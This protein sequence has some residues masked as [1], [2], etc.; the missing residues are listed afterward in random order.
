MI[1]IFLCVFFQSDCLYDYIRIED[2]SD[3]P[4]ASRF[5]RLLC[6][7][8]Y[9]P[10]SYAISGHKANLSF[11]SDYDTS[12]HGFHLKWKAIN[13]SQ[14]KNQWLNEPSGTLQSMNYPISY[15]NDLVCTTVISVPELSRVWLKV[16]DLDLSEKD[17]NC[18]DNLTMYLDG[19]DALYSVELCAWN[20]SDTPLQFLSL[21]NRTEIIFE[22]DH[23]H[24][25]KGYQIIYK[26]GQYSIDLSNPKLNMVFPT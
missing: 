15:L 7:Q 21:T 9:T 22:S 25:G 12:G 20:N 1:Y 26:E 2:L 4:D 23:F 16:T 19:S 18:S 10:V 13:T 14:C 8:H 6:G 5:T 3:E 17:V 24:N 11:S